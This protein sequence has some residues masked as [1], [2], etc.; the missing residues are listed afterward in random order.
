MCHYRMQYSFLH[1]VNDI[2]LFS[3]LPSGSPVAPDRCCPELQIPLTEKSLFQALA[4]NESF[5]ASRRMVSSV[6]RA[7][8]LHIFSYDNTNST[9][10]SSGLHD[11]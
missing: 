7:D 9:S 1:R 6:S 4:V 2:L 8:L 5:S 3:F 10:K 11:Q